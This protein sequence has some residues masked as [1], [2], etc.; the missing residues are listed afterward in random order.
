MRRSQKDLQIS[1]RTL[2]RELAQFGIRKPEEDPA[3]RRA[4]LVAAL[5]ESGGSDFGAA[6]ILGISTHDGLALA[7]A[8]RRHGLE[9]VHHSRQ[10]LLFTPVCLH[11]PCA[12][13]TRH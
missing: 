7:Q 9:L 5:K 3:A 13:N 10:L 1:R 2:F 6:R 11:P 4:Q 12:L 8:A